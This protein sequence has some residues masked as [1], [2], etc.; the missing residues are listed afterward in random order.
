MRK[1][2]SCLE[3]EIMQGTM[4]GSSRRERPRTAWIDNI[5]T[6]IGLPVEE[7]ILCDKK[8]TAERP[9][10][11]SV[12]GLITFKLHFH[13]PGA[14]YASTWRFLSSVATFYLCT[15]FEIIGAQILF[16]G[17]NYFP[18][19]SLPS[20]PLLFVLVPCPSNPAWGAL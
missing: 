8:E 13:T 20:F 18:S 15:N 1:Q 5:N 16:S 9:R 10:D 4:P 14:D 17:C 12:D 11:V 3:K 7:L 2:G 19:I 6:W